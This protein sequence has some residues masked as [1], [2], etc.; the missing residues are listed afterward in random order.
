MYETSRGMALCIPA[1]SMI[2]L[3]KVVSSYLTNVI[4]KYIA[5]ITCDVSTQ[6]T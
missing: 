3:L 5:I 1:A 4:S 2:L 6:A